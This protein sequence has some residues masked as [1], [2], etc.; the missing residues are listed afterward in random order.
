LKTELRDVHCSLSRER[1]YTK[2][3]FLNEPLSD[4]PA[5]SPGFSTRG[6]NLFKIQ[7]WMCAV[8]GEPN[9]K[10]GGTDFKWGAGHHWL[11]RWLSLAELWLNLAQK[12]VAVLGGPNVG[13]NHKQFI[14]VKCHRAC[15]SFH[16]QY[17][18]KFQRQRREVILA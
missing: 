10:W 12:R 14:I 15:A 16:F 4:S 11:P 9:V 8:T 7:Y 1:N 5:L 3:R 17:L 6:G 2:I 13:Q 18:K